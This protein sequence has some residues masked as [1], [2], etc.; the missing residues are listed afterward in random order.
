[1]SELSICCLCESG[2]LSC[3]QAFEPGADERL[4]QHLVANCIYKC[5]PVFMDQY[6]KNII[7]ILLRAQKE[8]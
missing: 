4:P 1:M 2:P 7:V 8:K 5:A 3:Q 6:V